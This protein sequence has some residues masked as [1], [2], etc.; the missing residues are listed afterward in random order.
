MNQVKQTIRTFVRF[1]NRTFECGKYTFVPALLAIHVHVEIVVSPF[2]NNRGYSREPGLMI[3]YIST[4]TPSVTIAADRA[5]K[6]GLHACNY[7]IIAL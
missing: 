6:V 5:A 3:L 2:C 4:A 7:N 1:N